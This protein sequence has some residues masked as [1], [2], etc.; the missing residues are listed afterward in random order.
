MVPLHTE[1]N[2]ND[3]LHKSD[4]DEILRFSDNHTLCNHFKHLTSDGKRKGND[5]S[6]KGDH[7]KDQE[8]KDLS[9][10]VAKFTEHQS[11]VSGS[12]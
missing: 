4:F 9:L 10:Y 3:S 7:L 11:S 8:S 5:E 6:D 2:G 12:T 1:M